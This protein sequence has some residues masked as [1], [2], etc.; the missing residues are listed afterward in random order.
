MDLVLNLIGFEVQRKIG[1]LKIATME[2]EIVKELEFFVTQK[3]RDGWEEEEEHMHIEME[4][5]F[6]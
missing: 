3:L 2:K 4:F 6:H 1:R 5:D